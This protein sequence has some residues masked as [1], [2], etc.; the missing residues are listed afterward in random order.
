MAEDSAA[1]EQAKIANLESEKRVNELKAR[2]LELNIADLERTE[3]EELASDKNAYSYSFYDSVGTGSVKTAIK[4]LSIFSRKDPSAEI[5]V[6]F[7]SPGGN[8]IDGLALYDFIQE[9][10]DKGHKVETVSLGWAASMGGVLLQ[11]GTNRVAGKN[12]FMLIHEIGYG[13]VGKTSEM[14]DELKFTKRLQEKLLDILA[15][16]STY[17]KKQISNRWKYKDWWLD[18]NE[19][20]KLGFVDEIR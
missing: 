18:A 20:L 13:S 8:V 2:E 1:L 12:S 17:T 14:E 7:T 9:L 6:V 16:R 15:E 5:Q 19:Q 10:K 4:E 11:A 3:K